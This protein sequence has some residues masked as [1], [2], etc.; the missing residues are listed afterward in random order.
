MKLMEKNQKEYKKDIN[1]K[2]QHTVVMEDLGEAMEDNGEDMVDNGEVIEEAMADMEAN[3][4]NLLPLYNKLLYT[5]QHQ[6]FNKL[7]C[8]MAVDMEDMAVMVVLA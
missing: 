1:S 5:K 3:T 2:C 8:L 6:E 4:D 7:I